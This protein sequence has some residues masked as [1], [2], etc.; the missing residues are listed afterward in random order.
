MTSPQ[1]AVVGHP[2]KGKSSIVATL[3]RQDAVAISE[4]SGTTTR[5]QAFSLVVD[6]RHIYTLVDTPGFQ[7]P[8]QV[9]AWLEAHA[10]NAAERI[11]AVNAF[12]AHFSAGQGDAKYPDE[13]Q[14]LSPIMAGAGIIYVV[15]GSVPY[16]PEYEAEMTILQWTGQPRMALINPIG[17]DQYGDQW[18]RAL[19]QYFNVVR[20]F[21]PMTADHQ[22]QLNVL[23]AFAELHEPWRPVIESSVRQLRDVMATQVRTSATL[24]A[25]TLVQMLQ[26]QT[27]VRV[28]VLVAEAAL[29]LTLK[30]RYEQAMRD[31]E[32]GLQRRLQE[33]FMQHR[34]A[35]QSERLTADYPDLFDRSSWLMFGLQRPQ[36]LGLAASA[37]A[38]AGAVVDVSV[39][40]T[41]LMAGAVVGGL[42]S[43]AASFLAT[44][45]PEKLTVRGVPV[46]GKELVAG[47]MNDL[48][49][50]FVL[51]GRA[52]DFYDLV[53]LRTHA[54]RQDAR[55]ITSDMSQR[56]LRLKRL[57]QVRLAHLL[58]KAHK[59]L[60]DREQ[61]QLAEML[62]TLMNPLARLDPAISKAQ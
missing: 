27:E 2:N 36:L 6:G 47:P 40:G 52:L 20:V 22:S 38:A 17:G 12:L 45:K 35:V 16:T 25:E 31:L 11:G 44:L 7:R 55:L 23:A 54:D 9:L 43:G 1:F 8:R 21:N 13:R 57:D 39:G 24:M 41:S 32:M 49:F 50:A 58:Q 61:Q 5:A 19:S 3:A 4:L 33:L 30:Q 26:F 15:D 10:T 56:M 18:A 48:N 34:L 59:G 28:P 60:G 42:L 62:L 29:T 37:G 51:L 14:L 46:A 53:A